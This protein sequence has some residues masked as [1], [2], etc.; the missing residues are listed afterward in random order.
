[1]GNSL[2]FTPFSINTYSINTRDKNNCLGEI[3][4]GLVRFIP[5]NPD[6]LPTYSYEFIS[7]EIK[8]SYN[9]FL[10][11]LLDD[12]IGLKDK[13]ERYE[14]V[15]ENSYKERVC[16]AYFIVKG[17]GW[18]KAENNSQKL[19]GNLITINDSE[20]NNW[21]VNSYQRFVTYNKST[22]NLNGSADTLPR[23]WMV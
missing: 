5:K 17:P 13:F 9:G 12:C 6:F 1:M 7:G 4:N 20:E 19:G 18:L 3:N 14:F 22:G 15:V 23:A 11:N 21:V 10:K 8:R 2:D 16:S